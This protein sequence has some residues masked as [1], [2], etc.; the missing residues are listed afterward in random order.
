MTEIWIALTEK[1]GVISGPE[2]VDV[3]QKYG[4]DGYRRKAI[5]SLQER[6]FTSWHYRYMQAEI[7]AQLGEKD[8]AFE[9]LNKALEERDHRMA[10]L[11]VNP[12]LD[13]LRSDPR[14]IQLLRQ[15]NLEN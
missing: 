4:I 13:N 8:A 14:F 12:K 2:F 15:M 10:Q 3:Y 9:L 6:Q 1:M 5:E 11:R 7:H